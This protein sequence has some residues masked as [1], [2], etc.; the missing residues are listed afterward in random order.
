MRIE[1]EG[2]NFFENKKFSCKKFLFSKKN[3]FF[4]KL[5]VL[6]FFSPPLSEGISFSPENL[7][8][9]NENE[10]EN[11]NVIRNFLK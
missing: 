11:E 2:A 3:F 4:K 1:H 9:S 5:L 8:F 6:N 10:N 7:K